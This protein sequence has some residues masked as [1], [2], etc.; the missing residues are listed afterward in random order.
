MKWRHTG[1]DRKLV[2]SGQTISN[3]ST[4][5]DEEMCTT[6]SEEDTGDEDEIDVTD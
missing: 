4:K 6:T 2:N 3:K 1:E 5:V